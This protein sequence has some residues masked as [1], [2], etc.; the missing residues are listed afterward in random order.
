MFEENRMTVID[1]DGKE[2]EMEIIL[3]FE[4]EGKEYVL[5]TDPNDEEGNVFACTY[6]EDGEMNPV[7]DEKEWEVCNE[8]LGAFIDETEGEDDGD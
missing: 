4:H 7:T 6:T 5:F 3:T 2:V 8:V 1:D